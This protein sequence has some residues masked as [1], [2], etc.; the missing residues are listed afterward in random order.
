MS[1][2]LTLIVLY[3]TRFSSA[4]SLLNAV[5]R[6]HL[7]DVQY[8]AKRLKLAEELLNSKTKI[9]VSTLK[10]CPRIKSTTPPRTMEQT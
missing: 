3:F 4:F 7:K 1:V 9:S 2:S 10:H 5:K 6:Q 8:L